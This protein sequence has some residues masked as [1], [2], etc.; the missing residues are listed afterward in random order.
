MCVMHK[1]C[2]QIHVNAS[3]SVGAISAPN[4]GVPKLAAQMSDHVQTAIMISAAPACS[5]T[6]DGEA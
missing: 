3:T 6:Y 4:V 1:L 5:G 2:Y